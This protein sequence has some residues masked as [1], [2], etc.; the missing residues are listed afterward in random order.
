MLNRILNYLE[1][2]STM[3][4]YRPLK[5]RKYKKE[6][7]VSSSTPKKTDIFPDGSKMGQIKNIQMHF[8]IPDLTYLMGHGK[9]T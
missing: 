9:S 6:T 4:R 5:V 2:G 1:N 3:Y 7:V 8:F